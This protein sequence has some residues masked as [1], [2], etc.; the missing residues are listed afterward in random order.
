[1]PVLTNLQQYCKGKKKDL[2]DLKH[3]VGVALYFSPVF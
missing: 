2:Y 1:M 3:V